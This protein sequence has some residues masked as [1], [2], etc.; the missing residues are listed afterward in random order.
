[1]QYFKNFFNQIN[2]S[3]YSKNFYQ[4]LENTDFSYTIKYLAKL[5]FFVSFLSTSL[6]LI[7][8]F[9]F[10]LNVL[11]Y[12]GVQNINQLAQ[13]YLENNFPSELVININNGVLST[14]TDQPVTFPIPVEWFNEGFSSEENFRNF[15]TVSPNEPIT[16]NSFEKY[17]SFA[18]LS[19][20]TGAIYDIENKS[21]ELFQYKDEDLQAIQNLNINKNSAGETVNI[22]SNYV[23][24]YFPYFLIS[25]MFAYF[26]FVGIFIFISTLIFSLFTTLISFLVGRFSNIEKDFLVWYKKTIHADTLYIILV[27]TLGFVFPFAIVPFSNTI[28]VLLVLYFNDNFKK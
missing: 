27:W 26:F 3:I 22:F 14:N 25:F 4:N 15:L 23:F 12:S 1:M 2:E 20:T 9:V 16:L 8:F 21:I 19:S 10:K 5:S 24:K 28:L 17:K 7:L 13:D 11:T 6:L 18:I